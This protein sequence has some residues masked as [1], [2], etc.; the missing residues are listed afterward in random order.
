MISYKKN[1]KKDCE[2]KIYIGMVMPRTRFELAAFA[3][4]VQRSTPELTRRDKKVP[5][6]DNIFHG[7]FHC[8]FSDIANSPAH[9]NCHRGNHSSRILGRHIRRNALEAMTPD[10]I[11]KQISMRMHIRH[12]ARNECSMVVPTGHTYDQLSSR[13]TT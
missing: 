7:V 5:L 8:C 12:A 3:L 11:R 13:S 9:K 6:F 2:P 1:G 10:I 4:Q